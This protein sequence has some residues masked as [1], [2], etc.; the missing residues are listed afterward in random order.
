MSQRPLTKDQLLAAMEHSTG[1]FWTIPDA[2]TQ[3]IAIQTD[4]V[5]NGR[6]G[7]FRHGVDDRAAWIGGE[8]TTAVDASLAGA[9]LYGMELQ[10]AIRAIPALVEQHTQE[11]KAWQERHAVQA[12][13]GEQI[14]EWLDPIAQTETEEIAA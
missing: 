9:D 4:Q 14:D 3:I 1:F 8:W 6:W 12:E 7:V 10:D 2:P 11:H 13:L 5:G